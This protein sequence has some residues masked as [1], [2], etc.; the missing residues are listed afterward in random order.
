MFGFINK[1]FAKVDGWKAILGYLIAQFAGS[2]PMLMVAFTAWVANKSDPQAVANLI[3]QL[4]LAGG[5]FHKFIKNVKNM[6]K[7]LPAA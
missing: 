1:L 7:G 2:Y 3:A 5:I 4:T 6:S